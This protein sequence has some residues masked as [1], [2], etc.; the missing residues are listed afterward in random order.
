[1]T[2][3]RTLL[4]GLFD[5]P[6]QPKLQA[7]TD[8]VT[9]AVQARVRS[10]SATIGLVRP[11]LF[12]PFPDDGSTD[13][14]EG[15]GSGGG[16]G[17]DCPDG[18]FPDGAGGCIDLGTGVGGGNPC[19]SGFVMDLIGNCIPAGGGIV[20]GILGGITGG[21]TNTTSSGGPA[22]VVVNVN[23]A[24]DIT[25]TGIQQVADEVKGAINQ[26]AQEA[27]NI[28]TQAA[29]TIAQ[30][31]GSLVNSIGRGLASAFS[32]IGSIISQIATF[33]WQ[34]I[35]DIFSAIGNGILDLVQKIKDFLGPILSSISDT[36]TAITKQV[37]YIN[38]T[39]I[40][41][42]ADI[43]NTTIKT[44]ATLTVAIQQDLHDGLSGILKIPSDIAA[45]LGSLDATLNRS[46]QQLGTI[47]KETV[48][49]GITFAGATLP[50]P[51]G[52]AMAK[53]LGG[54]VLTDKIKTTFGQSLTLSGESLQTVSNE[55]I[56]GLG[57]LLSEI[58]HVVFATFKAPLDQMHADWASVESV[59]VGLLDGVLGL[60]T[61]L[62]AMGALAS[63]LIDAAEQ[64]ART[65][66]P[67]RKLDP[68]TAIEALK[69]GFL[70]LKTVTSEIATTG[71][72]ATRQQVLIDLSIFL[73]DANQ[74]LD[75]W[76]RG[77]ID[78]T[79]LT[80]NLSSQGMT[81]GDQTAFKA[82]SVYLPS[83]ADLLR[84]LNFG[85]IN[86]DEF[87]QN[88]KYLRYDN[89]QIQTILTTYQDRI[90]A[91]R[92]MRLQGL[93]NNSSAV[94]IQHTLNIPVPSDVQTAG[95]REGLHPDTVKYL[96]D[97]HWELPSVHEFIHLYFRGIRT[98]T[99]VQQ[100]M[101]IANIPQELWDD[102]IQVE[103]LVIPHRSVPNY[104]KLG[105]MSVAKA[106]QE[107]QAQGFSV[108]DTQIILASVQAAQNKTTTT[109]STAVHTLS[110]TNAR[111]LW[112][113]GALTDLQYQ[114]LLEAHGYTADMALIQ[115]KADQI[116]LH[117]KSQKQTLADLSAEVQAGV[118]SLDD[119]SSQLRSNGF[120][121]A[122]I[123][124][125]QLSVAKALRVN[126]KHPSMADL[127][128]FLK[129]DLITLTDYA[130]ELQ[131]QGWADPWL[132]A[133]VAL[134][135]PADSTTP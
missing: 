30:S 82:A 68:A 53:Y 24:I 43:Y 115:M 113:E 111:E 108:E 75:W 78:D 106:T 39:L 131:A 9:P 16:Y 7:S 103:R 120:S 36:L 89:A 126:V 26:A 81:A 49:S 77:I 73:A 110:L 92:L 34:N 132:S 93:L 65:S 57:T 90:P 96:W 76:Y 116:N 22:N 27:G 67:T 119:A 97:G 134:E 87:T 42:I 135:T 102:M 41:P 54:S 109:A 133:F 125:F 31:L 124:R 66:V 44:I 94:F 5:R 59:F 11:T 107:L 61:T 74:A 83:I 86:Q 130:N 80:A 114:Q 38:D 37:Q 45:G 112:S 100:R 84:W 118:L 121:D 17:E 58:L 3:S 98:L 63:P 13:G 52:E 71:L 117:V 69:R 4:G 105:V 19:G 28:A 12:A 129:N 60:L 25:D 6:L 104:V 62:T 46:I 47:N 2:P 10:G 50:Q 20:G 8:A 99:E 15:G 18:S 101:S 88:C 35:K 56:Q 40:K 23:N 14:S 32:N 33:I 29:K 48:T 21:G 85:I 128:K 95:Q 127:A 55:A 123:S 64:Q 70:D 1:M 72:D 51:F 79:D 91:E 122:Q